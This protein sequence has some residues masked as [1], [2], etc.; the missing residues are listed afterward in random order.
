LRQLVKRRGLREPLQHLVGSTSFC[1]FE[2]HVTRDV[3]IPRPET[4]V[5]AEQAWQ[6]L[7]ARAQQR[8][9]PVFALDFGT[10]S[11][12]LAVALAQHVPAAQ[13]DA[14]DVSKAALAVAEQNVA[15]HQ[16]AGRIRLIEGNGLRALGTSS[17][18]DLIVSNPPYI[19][20]REISQLDPEVRE[21][22]P[23]LALDGGQDGLDFQRLLAR[24]AVPLLAPDAKLMSEFGD[25]QAQAVRQIFEDLRWPVEQIVPDLAGR[26]RII[27]ARRPES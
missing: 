2:V 17:A 18:Y 20:S 24:E 1:G 9:G 16:L 11:A 23:H 7:Q 3:L 13:I 22:D 14:L 27:I 21:H 12:C 10:G 8:P 19:P 25:G 15:R 26:P 4:E 6:F 5:L